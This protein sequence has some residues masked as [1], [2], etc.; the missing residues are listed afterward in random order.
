MLQRLLENGSI[1][2]DTPRDTRSQRK[3][4]KFVD[5]VSDDYFDPGP[6]VPYA[7][8]AGQIVEKDALRIAEAIAE[9]DPNLY[10]LYVDPD[11]TDGLAEAPYMVAEKCKDGHMRPVLTAWELDNRL[12]ERIR[13]A[14]TQKFMTYDDLLKFE[15]KARDDT[16]ARYKERRL[17]TADKVAHIMGIKSHYTVKDDQTGEIIHFYDDR[18]AERTGG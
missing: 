17:E 5:A 18:P 3:E 14:D 11:H 15:Q 9:Y 13:M 10:L 2:M 12:L 4:R 6:N 8:L 16:A 1:N 7:I